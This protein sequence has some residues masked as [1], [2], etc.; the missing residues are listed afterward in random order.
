MDDRSIRRISELTKL[1]RERA[2]TEEEMDERH[3]LRQNYLTAFRSQMRSQLDNTVVQY[4]DG[5]R[6]PFRDAAK[7][8]DK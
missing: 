1:S 8:K 6:V 2:L 5:S 3:R 7:K 4:P